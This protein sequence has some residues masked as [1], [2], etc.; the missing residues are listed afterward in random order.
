MYLVRVEG[1]GRRRLFG[2]QELES[3]FRDNFDVLY[4]SELPLETIL[5]CAVEIETEEQDDNP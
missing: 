1:E 3:Q 4:M 2:E 5:G